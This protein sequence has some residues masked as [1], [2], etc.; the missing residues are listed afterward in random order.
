MPIG[1]DL[2]G[3]GARG[4]AVGASDEVMVGATSAAVMGDT[5]AG[6]GVVRAGQ[7]AQVWAAE[8]VVADL[9]ARLWAVEAV[10][11]GQAAQVWAVEAVVA[12]L[13]EAVV[14][15]QVAGALVAAELAVAE[16]VVA[17]Q[18]AVEQV[19]VVEAAVAARS[20]S[21][22]YKTMTRYVGQPPRDLECAFRVL[23][24]RCM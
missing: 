13:V 7:A 5:L 10:V 15:R 6:T 8:A 1:A 22:K 23:R 9:V 2:V 16:L 12:D 21:L 18:V 14:A 3:A 24:W 4:S 19:V 11:A 20:S 17:E